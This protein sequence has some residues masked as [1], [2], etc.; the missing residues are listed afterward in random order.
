MAALLASVAGVAGCQQETG[1]VGSDTDILPTGNDQVRELTGRAA[2]PAT[3]PYAEPM[4]VEQGDGHASLIYAC[5]QARPEVLAEG[6]AGIISPEG[7][8]QPSPSLNMLVVNDRTEVIRGLPQV[9]A[10]LDRPVPQILVEARVVEVTVDKDLEQEIRHVLTVQ[11]NS[12]FQNSDITLLTPGSTPTIGQG[13]DLGV[14]TFSSDD[15]QINSF[16]RILLTRGRAKILSSPNVLVSAG[17]EAS[18]ITGQEVPVQSVTVVGSSLSTTTVFKR[19]GIK[20]RV[21][22]Q[23]IAGDTARLE[24][25]PEVSTVTGYTTSGATGA[26]TTVTN[27]I[28]AIRNVTSTLSMKDGEILTIGGLLSSEDRETVRGVPILMDIP[29]V[30]ALFRST[31]KQEARTQLIFFMRVHVLGEGSVDAIRVHKPDEGLKVLDQVANPTTMPAKNPTSLDKPPIL[32]K[33]GD[34]P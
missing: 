10:Q 28:I 15:A 29:V 14:R 2:R 13:L 4:V 7:S 3:R 25:N 11:G 19:V 16:V 12:F 18:I 1:G 6:I 32:E 33:E 24:L 31:R 20:L 34:K 23:Q 26:N 30:G 5:R 8:V 22:L 21:N 17:T 9:L 27:P